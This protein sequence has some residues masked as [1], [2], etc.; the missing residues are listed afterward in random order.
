MRS[1]RKRYVR[2]GKELNRSDPDSTVVSDGLGKP[3]HRQEVV[4]GAA[5]PGPSIVHPSWPK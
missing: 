4:P 3:S 5:Q 2:P 1:G